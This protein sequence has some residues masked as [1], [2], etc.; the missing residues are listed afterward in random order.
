M[1]SLVAPH[2][3]SLHRQACLSLYRS[4]LRATAGVR[5]ATSSPSIA[6]TV[7]SLIRH[8]FHK[9]QKLLSRTQVAN[10]LSAGHEYL[11]LLRSCAAKEPVA[12]QRLY[13]TLETVARRADATAAYRQEMASRWKPPPPSRHAHLRNLR[14]NASPVSHASGS[15]S[16]H[17]DTTPRIFSHPAPISTIKSG[18]RKTPNL[19]LTQGIPLVKYPGP[20]PVLVNRVLKQKILWGVRK[21]EQHTGLQ[22]TIKIAELEDE[23]DDILADK[24]GVSEDDGTQQDRQRAPI[25][26]VAGS[27]VR[28]VTPQ[29]ISNTRTSWTKQLE[30]VHYEI[31][32]AVM[33]RGKKYAA[34]GD[35]LWHEVVVKERDLKEKERKEKKHERRR[36]SRAANGVAGNIF[37]QQDTEAEPSS[38]S[39]GFI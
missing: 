21:W 39:S 30:E 31:R 33:E 23:W 24:E 35:R 37:G 28:L 3:S 36:E 26:Q 2:K 32:G 12:L 6:D 9:D 34:L 19:M 14:L 20:M 5:V 17:T 38:V 1:T 22:D 7:H 10:G 16:D 27:R 25:R 18:V 8:R 29:K 13:S 4:L 15:L 11:T